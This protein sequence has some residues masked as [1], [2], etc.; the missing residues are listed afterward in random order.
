MV[1]LEWQPCH[2]Y[3][4]TL[5]FTK[6]SYHRNVSLA[7]YLP[8]FYFS[9]YQKTNLH[10][11]KWVRLINTYIHTLGSYWRNGSI[12]FFNF[13]SIIH[14]FRFETIHPQEFAVGTGCF[15]ANMLVRCTLCLKSIFI[16]TKS[17]K[18]PPSQPSQI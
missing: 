5:F 9:V 13:W 8:I 6:I 15:M 18:Q 7:V 4:E 2:S 10:L 1:F 17:K 14:L 11:Y 3:T 12:N 16:K